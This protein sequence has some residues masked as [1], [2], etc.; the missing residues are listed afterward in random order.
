M[1]L[2][3]CRVV[4]VVALPDKAP[5]KVV[6]VTLVNPAIVVAV[7]PS[8]IDVLPIVTLE[9]ASLLTAILAEAE[10]SA[11][12]RD[13]ERLSLLYAILPASIVFVTVP[14]SPVVMMVPVVAGRVIVVV[15]AA[16]AG[17]RVTVPEVAPG[18][19]T[20]EIPVRA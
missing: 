5:V 2:A 16:A 19:A 12:T 15:P 17:C 9:A 10:I 8:V 6:A 1:V 20:L 11:F 4:A 13:P 7:L 3:V 14:L 18:N